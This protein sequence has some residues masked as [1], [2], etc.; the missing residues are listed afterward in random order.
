MVSSGVY[1]YRIISEGK[2]I[3]KKMMLIK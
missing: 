1:F 3:T 2:M